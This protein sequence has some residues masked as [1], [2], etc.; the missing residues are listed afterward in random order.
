MG[1]LCRQ[2]GQRDVEPER[3]PWATPVCWTCL[4]PTPDQLARLHKSFCGPA[5]P[6]H[7]GGACDL[8]LEAGKP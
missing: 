2:C 7:M 3:M 5:C 1:V 6:K 4:P 8:A